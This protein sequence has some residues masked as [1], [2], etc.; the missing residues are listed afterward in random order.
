MSKV[1]YTRSPC[2]SRFWFV[3]QRWVAMSY[4]AI[5]LFPFADPDEKVL[6]TIVTE[7]ARAHSSS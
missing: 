6:T 5:A 7:R 2:C 1:H 4:T 3:V